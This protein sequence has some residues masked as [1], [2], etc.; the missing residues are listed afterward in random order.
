GK[1]D[2]KALPTPDGEAYAVRA[3]EAPQGEVETALAAI[4]AEV[5]NLDSQQIG[6]NDHFF[7]LGGHSLLA[8]RVVSRI[9]EVLGV[10]L[11][12]TELFTHTSLSALATAVGHAAQSELPAIT[13]ASRA[14]ALPLS[15]AQQRLWFLSQM[16]GVSQAYHI[17]LGLRMQ[18]TLDR[19]ALQ[20]A[21]DRI[22][23]RHEALR[24]TFVLEHGQPVQRIAA[25]TGFVLQKHDL[26]NENDAETALSELAEAEAAAPF[27]LA[28]G[29]LVRGRLIRMADD[30]HVLLVTMHHIVSDGWS[31]GVLINEF[32][33][34]YNAFSNGK[35]DPLSPLSIQYAD[36][37]VWQR[38]WIDGE[39][40]QAQAAYWQQTL[41]GAPALLEL[42]T[43]RPRPAVQD[44]A[45]DVVGLELDAELTAGL[46]ALSRR[47]G[48]TLFMTVLAGWAAVLSRL[49]GQDEVVIGTPMA[50]R[51]RAEV[52]P[53]MGLFLNTLALRIDLSGQRA[54]GKLLQHVKQQALA[55]QQ[56]QDLP[57]EQVVE[58]VK[59][60]RSLAHSPLFQ[61]M[62]AWQNNDAGR[63]EL[64]GI[65]C[66]PYGAQGSTAKFDLTLNL[67][68]DGDVVAGGLEYATALFERASVER[69]LGY[70]QRALTAMV[71][72]DSLQ[73][74]WL[75]LLDEQ[76]RTQLLVDWNATHADY[77]QDQCI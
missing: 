1:L 15:F 74:A 53:L 24:T 40:L 65:D 13:L 16:E 50:G 5:L 47:H 55:A 49:S 39:V 77:P 46:K 66:M 68:E 3:Y 8:M 28:T 44:Y 56:H 29:P 17:P 14:D 71:D 63:L 43:D 9:R 33:A 12:V 4:W 11:G 51:L 19:N 31:Q 54:V 42:P 23:A 35:E 58:L 20:Q 27:D 52:E 34:L 25:D 75:P 57:F 67:G 69:M 62:F 61:V 45:G 21:L 36:Y 26:R 32:S 70:L 22:V 59:P 6:R 38:R 2:R 60:E 48:T 30:E 18:G 64:P 73:V 41:A 76:E 10:E 37:A 72:N 7:D